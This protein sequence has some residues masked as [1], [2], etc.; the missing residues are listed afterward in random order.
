MSFNLF[1][2]PTGQDLFGI[3]LYVNSITGQVTNTR[4]NAIVRH[5]ETNRFFVIPHSEP[6]KPADFSYAV[7]FLRGTNNYTSHLLLRAELAARPTAN[8]GDL[9]FSVATTVTQ[10]GNSGQTFNIIENKITRFEFSTVFASTATFITSTACFVVTQMSQS[11]LELSRSS[12]AAGG[13]GSVPLTAQISYT[14]TAS[15]ITMTYK[16]RYLDTVVT[17]HTL[18]FSLTYQAPLSRDL[19]F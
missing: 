4:Q 10:D 1:T 5:N 7:N 14:V 11:V 3:D 8:S 6:V 15:F 2:T 18:P 13:D 16:P 12:L 9:A 17:I 19:T